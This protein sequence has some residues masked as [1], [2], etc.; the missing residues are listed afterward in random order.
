[1][2][3]ANNKNADEDTSICPSASAFLYYQF[4]CEMSIWAALVVNYLRLYEFKD[5]YSFFRIYRAGDTVG[6][7]SIPL[8]HPGKKTAQLYTTDFHTAHAAVHLVQ[9]AMRNK[10]ALVIRSHKRIWATGL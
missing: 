4:S 3:T 5:S 9:D 7:G 6:T 2:W 10:I 8:K 1:M